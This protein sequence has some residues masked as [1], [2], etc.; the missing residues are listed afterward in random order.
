MFISHLLPSDLSCSPASVLLG[1][2]TEFLN[3][4]FQFKQV[5]LYISKPLNFYQ[6]FYQSLFLTVDKY[7]HTIFVYTIFSYFKMLFL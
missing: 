3:G 7:P 5:Y 2:N 1:S 4:L 6:N